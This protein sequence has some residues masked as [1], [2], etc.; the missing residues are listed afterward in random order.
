MSKRENLKCLHRKK[1]E[2]MLMGRISCT[3]GFDNYPHL[4]EG[5]LYISASMHTKWRKQWIKIGTTGAQKARPAKP[6]AALLTLPIS[7]LG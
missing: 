2:L 4:R 6:I 7:A 3:V 5:F 1:I